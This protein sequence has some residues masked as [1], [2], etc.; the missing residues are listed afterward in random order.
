MN[1][2]QNRSLAILIALAAA[3][4]PVAL[5][6]AQDEE[7]LKPIA[8]PLPIAHAHNDYQHP[9]P[10]QDALDQGFCSVEA[11]VHLI[12][13]KL[14]V[15]HDRGQTD[16]ERT[17]EKL[18][19][20]PLRKRAA[21]LS[22]HIFP[23]D[24]PPPFYLLIDVKSDADETYQALHKVLEGYAH[25]LTP[26]K[27]GTPEP[28]AVTVVLSGNRARDLMKSQKLRYAGYDGRLDDLGGGETAGFMPWISD[29]WSTHF[30]WRGEG[31]IPAEELA[32]LKELVQRTHAE[33]KMLRLWAAP[34]SPAGWRILENANVDLIN[35]DRL[36]ELREFFNP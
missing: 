35:T 3:G 18:Y 11:D 1:R 26:F 4:H 25:I 13:G 7:V 21:R 30:K 27:G 12:D 10:L 32:K 16:P 33:G 2:L 15:A 20:D 17:L 6:E 28:G 5:L 24:P 22:G 23:G 36:A 31:E 19:L 8:T 29:S 14:L 9:R 34:D